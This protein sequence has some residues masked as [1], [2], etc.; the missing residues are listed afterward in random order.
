MA[1]IRS[2]PTAL[3]ILCWVALCWMIVASA[4][5]VGKHVARPVESLALAVDGDTGLSRGD[6]VYLVSSHGLEQVGEVFS[7]IPSSGRVR[8][9]LE[10]GTGARLTSN[11]KATCWHTPLAAEDV[12]PALLPRAIQQ[13]IAQCIARDWQDHE[14]RLAAAWAPVASELAHAFLD[15][16]AVD[17]QESI[18]VR[19]DELLAIAHQ[20][21]QELARDWPEIQSRVNPIIE[22]HLTPVLGRLMND[23]ISEAPKITIAWHV[24]KGETAEAYQAMLNWLGDYLVAMPDADRKELERAFQN[25]WE[26]IRNDPVLAEHMADLGRRILNDPQLRD[27][28]TAIYREAIVENPKTADLLRRRLL[29]SETV[30]SHM[31]DFLETFGPTARSAMAILLF[32]DRG[33][34]R[35]EVV[36]FIRSTTLRRQVAW[37]TLDAGEKIAPP[38]DLSTV[39]QADRKGA[40]AESNY[41][42]GVLA[43]L[44]DQEGLGEVVFP[45]SDPPQSSLGKEG[46]N[47]AKLPTNGSR[48]GTGNGSGP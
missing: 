28:L 31:Y 12:L 25:T 35:P 37:V 23:A 1:K 48:N 5:T 3:G 26:A 46:G 21:A 13:R 8:L 15:I 33:R 16:I 19:R 29:E 27:T 42:A 17:V 11:T 7:A 4:G 41:V 32:D 44:P 24:A 22:R 45:S 9:R 30:R 36:Q 18:H 2:G 34:T 14:G 38:F 40:G 20:H 47:S 6:A 43:P 39:L 10:Q